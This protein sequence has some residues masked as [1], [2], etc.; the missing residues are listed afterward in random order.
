VLTR[1]GIV[2]GGVAGA[3]LAWRVRQAVRRVAIDVYTA[4]TEVDASAVSGGMVRGFERSAD[5]CRLAAESLAELRGDPVL[6]GAAGYR[7]IGSVY[8][9]PP[10]TDPAGPVRVVEQLLPGSAT[11]LAGGHPLATTATAVVERHAGYLSPAALRDAVLGWL[12]GDGVTIR[13]VP[14]TRLDPA[15]ALRSA[16]GEIRG[17]DAVVVAAG[18]WTPALLAASDLPTDGLRTKQIQYTVY[19]GR[20]PG[21]AFVDDL[22]GR[23]G[24]PA[25]VGEF[26]LGLPCDRWDVDPAALT[27]DTALA[28]RLT[29]QATELLG[30]VRPLTTRV[31]SD[32]YRDPAGLV[33]REVKDALFTFT[34]GSGGAAK[35]V[36]AASRVAAA[37]LLG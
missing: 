9:L 33:L 3:L 22:T 34:G 30:D 28:D 29:R 20:L 25:G 23:Y 31:S 24:R 13:P 2:G 35:S 6:R 19:R 16:D 8:L 36:L 17:Y 32:C 12:A 4:P 7:E 10:G 1:V 11:V 37:R 5:A 15:P 14:V 27:P 26:L 18:P 21:G